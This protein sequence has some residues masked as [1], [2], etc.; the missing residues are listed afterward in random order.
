MSQ[1]KARTVAGFRSPEIRPAVMQRVVRMLPRRRGMKTGKKSQTT[2]SPVEWGPRRQA[3]V[4]RVV[5]NDEH[6]ADAQ[7]VEESKRDPRGPCV[8]ENDREE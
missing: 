7:T 3:S 1:L 6:D 2:Q 5:L 8:R 4:T